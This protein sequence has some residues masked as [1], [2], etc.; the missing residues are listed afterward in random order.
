[1]SFC[2]L[3]KIWLKKLIKI[4]LI[5]TNM[6]Q[7]QKDSDFFDESGKIYNIFIDKN[8]EKYTIREENGEKSTKFLNEK[9][10]S[11]ILSIVKDSKQSKD[12]LQP[13]VKT[14]Y[15]SKRGKVVDITEQHINK[16][17]LQNDTGETI[18]DLIVL[19]KN[20]KSINNNIQRKLKDSVF[21]DES[22]KIHNIFIDENNQ[23]YITY[24]ENGKRNIRFLNE[25]DNILK[26]VVVKK[27]VKNPK[28]NAVLRKDIKTIYIDKN[29]K[30][31]NITEKKQQKIVKKSLQND[32]QSTI[33]DLLV[34][35]EIVKGVDNSSMGLKIR[36]IVKKDLQIAFNKSIGDSNDKIINIFEQKLYDKYG[37]NIKYYLQGASKIMLFLDKD[38]SI[39]KFAELFR[40]KTSQGIYTADRLVNLDIT[41]MLPEVFLNPKTSPSVKLQIYNQLNKLLITET[42]ELLNKIES[43]LNP[44]QARKP[45]VK[46]SINIKDTESLVKL[47]EMQV[48]KLCENPY[49]AMK[50]VNIIICR[51][52]KKF[53]CLDIKQLLKQIAE[54]GKATNYFTSSPLDDNINNN[55]RN[56]YSK[57][58]EEL[59]SG[60]EINIG[61]TTLD[62][63]M[64][65]KETL[66]GLEK[67]KNILNENVNINLVR[68]YGIDE[69]EKIP[70]NGYKFIPQLI[71]DKFEEYL[72]EDPY[73]GIDK[74][75][76]WLDENIIL[77]KNSI[78]DYID[79]K[80]EQEIE[81]LNKVLNGLQ[82]LKEYLNDTSDKEY[83]ENINFVRENGLYDLK[84]DIFVPNILRD[85]F[86][87]FL[88]KNKKPRIEKINLWLDENINFIEKIL[89]NDNE[90]LFYNNVNDTKSKKVEKI[91]ENVV[92]VQSE[93]EQQLI[94]E[95]ILKEGTISHLIFSKDISRL[96][97]MQQAI[98]DNLNN[99][100][101]F[102]SR[103]ELS[104]NLKEVHK[105]IK[106]VQDYGKSI[107]G[108]ILLLKSA[109]MSNTQKFATLSDAIG[110][111]YIYPKQL[112]ATKVEIAQLKNYIEKIQQEIAYLEEQ[113]RNIVAEFSSEQ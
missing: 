29:G 95:E 44:S 107:K 40:K 20:N 18:K 59:K 31:V 60:K 39:G 41:E 15:V 23:K 22:G 12:E 30:V 73:S 94:K 87:Q 38:H 93:I 55:L 89:V 98:I 56:R 57:Q 72:D 68:A 111:Q 91:V 105:Q 92:N 35:N 84:N 86:K 66:A 3:Y 27:D 5:N 75:N 1:M 100:L 77:I 69:M 13:Y 82:N 42:N 11:K 25:N 81:Y 36:D 113:D 49:W 37:N 83:I 43:I 47:N 7:K 17:S 8:N 4:L 32:Q 85:K 108:I 33:K 99:E 34:L 61:Y 50:E 46:S 110:M 65:L 106:K 67:F 26:R 101:D 2:N 71:R 103:N 102:S 88:A 54:T 74:I 6:Q 19:N 24:L 21:F 64:D 97:T 80:T 14:F 96:E 62:E 48:K 16:K 78:K 58:I 109:L 63:F 79:N 45:Y 70:D 28:T 52:N 104:N 76:L 53:Y 9:A 51:D 90:E 112:E 10:L